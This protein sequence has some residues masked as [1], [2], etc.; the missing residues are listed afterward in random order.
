MSESHT[1]SQPNAGP[2]PSGA[3]PA[4]HSVEHPAVHDF[5]GPL[6]PKTAK[7]IKVFFACSLVLFILDFFVKRHTHP[8]VDDLPGFYPVYGFVGCVVLVLV[9]KEM[10][11]V[12]MRDESYYDAPED[13]E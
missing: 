10:R 13:D 1:G 6:S 4:A 11:K 8:G 7:L 12:L 9:A 3:R 5:T 2:D